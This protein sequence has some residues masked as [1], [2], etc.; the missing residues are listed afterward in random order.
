VLLFP[1]KSNRHYIFWTFDQFVSVP[2]ETDIRT[3]R[4]ILKSILNDLDMQSKMASINA[5]LP[6]AFQTNK[7]K[8][9]SEIISIIYHRYSNHKDLN[10][11]IDH[12]LF[13]QYVIKRFKELRAKQK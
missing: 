9:D 11:F 2:D 4:E 12:P 3:W 13:D 5:I 8:T 10:R 7:D 6:S 1:N